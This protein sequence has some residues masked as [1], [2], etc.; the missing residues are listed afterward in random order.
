MSDFSLDDILDKY[1]NKGGSGSVDNADDILSDILGEKPSS[2]GRSKSADSD[3]Y[4]IVFGKDPKNG[5]ASS[6]NSA[7]DSSAADR[8]AAEEKRR[9]ELEEKRLQAEKRRAEFEEKQRAAEEKKREELARKQ[10]IA[11]EKKREELAKKQKLEEERRLAELEA[12][13]AREEKKRREQEEAERRRIEEEEKRREE[14]ARLEAEEKLRLEQENEK[15][16]AEEDEASRKLEAERERLAAIEAEKRHKADEEAEKRFATK[17]IV[18]QDLPIEMPSSGDDEG[19]YSP[20]LPDDQDI[21]LEKT[22][23]AQKIQ[24]DSQKLLIKETELEDPDDFLNAINPYEFGK[25]S[26]YTQQIETI[27]SEGLS[28]DTIGVDSNELRELLRSTQT[29]PQVDDTRS[30]ERIVGGDTRVMPDIESKTGEYR[31]DPDGTFELSDDIKEFIPR[32]RENK[33]PRKHSE[34]EERVLKSINDTIE[35]KRLSDKRDA[36]PSSVY[37]T[38][39]FDKIIIPTLSVNVESEGNKVLRTGEIPMSDPELA[40]QKMK[41]LASKRKRRLSSVVLEDIADDDIDFYDDSDQPEAIDDDAGIWTDIVETQKSLRLRSV[42][43]FIVTLGLIVI[44]VLQRVF[45]QQKIGAFGN[46]IGLLD[47]KGIVFA[48]LICG[49]IGMVLCSSVMTSGLGKL[50]RLR[51]DCDSVCAV[52]CTL[53]LI[54]SVLHLM[55]TNDLQQGR[56]FIYIPV[57]LLGLLFNSFGKLSMIARA[58]RNYRFISSDASRY[59]AE[60]IDGQSE[61][62]AFTKGVLSELP[63]LVTMRKT[64]L[65]TDF[66]KKSYCED[67]ADR[68]SRKLVPISLAIG[69]VMGLVAYFVPNGNEV[70][71]VKVFENNIY[72]ASSVFVAF[73]TIMS[74]F[75]MMFMVNNPF[76]RASK[77]M[78]KHG[79]TLLGYTSA[80]EFGETNSVL[81]DASTLFPKSAVE[82]TNIKPCKLQNS[83]NSISLD[84][85]IIL[86]ASLAVSSESVMSSLLFD[87]IG[88]N[89]DMLVKI[90]GCVYEDNMGVMGWYENKR[91]ILG[92]REHM[93]HH[94]IK[95]PEMSAIAKYSRNGSDSVYL[96]VGGEL[97]V[98]FFIRLTAN[99][100]VRSELKELTDRGVSV[101]LK[102]TDS[103]ITTGKIS[104]LFD[105]DPEKIKIIGASLHKLY[106]EC[107]AYT[108]SGCGALS[109]TGSFVSLAKGINASKKLLK[110][111]SMSRGVM[112]FGIVVGVLFLIFLSFSSYTFVFSPEILI[113]WNMLWL[114]IMLFLQGF[115]RY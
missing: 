22:L 97:A 88:G 3:P 95:I 41:E 101:H 63:Y 77:K 45:I 89:K 33:E 92:S 111:V 16:R 69:L 25:K 58:R 18:L 79:G 37:D 38:G 65:F 43:L 75:S 52:S 103:L 91:L 40:E 56:A 10:R 29:P 106:G 71:G 7:A 11:E 1:G 24:I 66:L 31:L 108:P 87:M 100:A 46:E 104:D 82:C 44:D 85:A 50:F 14:N 13:R 102:T 51:P 17:S 15:R 112:L 42:L 109:C 110:D 68:V 76:R 2:A 26:E 20:V 96:A 99:P 57:T 61:A 114:A 83:I 30:I 27:S 98:I 34:E 115:R 5:D 53:S 12:A 23:R 113:G 54:A 64:E 4:K 19:A 55:D 39:P 90:D 84:Q 62:S 74:P 59:Y 80:E 94:S 70:N 47:S 49:V 73:V 6:D 72:W 21:E 67:L 36:D 28:G 86:A 107:T 9:R 35:Q 105:I 8:L 78:L 48:N 32:T 81:V 60:V 93:K